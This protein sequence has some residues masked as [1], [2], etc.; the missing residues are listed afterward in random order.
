V[1][2]HSSLN[3]TAL[4]ALAVGIA[5]EVTEELR[6]ART[7]GH[8][9]VA[10][11]S[12]TTDLVT[13]MDVWSE[14]HIVRR[15]LDA[16]PNDGIVGEEGA[17]HDSSSGVRWYIDPID[18]TTNYTYGHWGCSVSIGA[19]I[20]GALAVAVVHDPFTGELFTATLG[21]G[22]FRNGERLHCS[23]RDDLSLALV[24]TGFGYAEERRSH[25]ARTL[26]HVLP[27]IRDIRRMGGAAIDLCSVGLGRVDAYYERGL[28]P[29][30]VAAGSLVAQESGAIVT[31]LD[32]N[33]TLGYGVVVAAPPQLH[34]KLVQLLIDA[35]A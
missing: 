35:G 5:A 32:G 4:L 12:S 31:D 29:W 34:D 16:R 11:K 24:A 21:G 9:Q 7:R 27:R 14:R 30:D 10:T 23:D 1:A 26:T 25:Q 20:D 3:T 13:E 15:L 2:Q 33:A 17:A 8:L 22:A 6:Q 18:G 28:S 19:E